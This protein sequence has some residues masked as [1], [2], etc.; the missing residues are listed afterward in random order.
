MNKV[1]NKK[2]KTNLNDLPERDHTS[3]KPYY[4]SGEKEHVTI[5]DEQPLVVQNQYYFMNDA[6]PKSMNHSVCCRIIH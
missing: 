6:P 2:L 4:N 1:S 5:S 3:D